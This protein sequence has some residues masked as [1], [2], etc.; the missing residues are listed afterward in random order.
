ML[1]VGTEREG[2]YRACTSVPG[3]AWALVLQVPQEVWLGVVWE[4]GLL[5]VE[6][7]DRTVPV[8]GLGPGAT[9]R[10]GSEEYQHYHR[11]P[12][13]RTTPPPLQG[14]S[15]PASVIVC[16]CARFICSAGTSAVSDQLHEG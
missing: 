4:P 6:K 15:Q 3:G 16:R 14:C 2:P 11:K 12:G 8:D 13:L 7:G 9:L 5:R 1:H 10:P